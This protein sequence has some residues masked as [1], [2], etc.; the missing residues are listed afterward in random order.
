MSKKN[1]LEVRG[2]LRCGV[3]VPCARESSRAAT[4][5][6]Y[7]RTYGDIVV[8][9][10]LGLVPVSLYVALVHKA[11]KTRNCLRF[12][13]IIIIIY[14]SSLCDFRWLKSAVIPVIAVAELMPWM[15]SAFCIYCIRCAQ[16]EKQHLMLWIEK[17][18]HL[19]RGFPK[20]IRFP[21]QIFLQVVHSIPIA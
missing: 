18:N 6:L 8:L 11:A 21:K 13:M 15:P 7:P 17:V 1:E 4:A 9:V 12:S 5:D 19:Y 10:L 14:Y 2:W 16:Q 3:G 20:P